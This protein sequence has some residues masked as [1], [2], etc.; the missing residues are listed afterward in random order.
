MKTDRIHGR[1]ALVTGAGRGL[2]EAIARALAARGAR[3]ILCDIDPALLDPLAD[4][5]G[6]VDR[7]VVDVADPDA[8][9][10]LADRIHA[11]HGP[12]GVL[13]NNAGVVAA[14]PALEMPLADWRWMLGVN[15]MGVL[16]GCHVFGPA[17]VAAPGR[18]H[19]VNIASAA[20]FNGLPRMS[21]YAVSK[22]AV[23]S[24]S[25]SL[26]MEIPHGALGISV[27]CPGFI[28]TRLA[29]TGRYPAGAAGEAIKASAARVMDRRGR[30]PADVGRAVISAIDRDRFLVPLYTESW[31]ALAG[32]SLPS[33]VRR[34]LT[35]LATRWMGD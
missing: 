13:V 31:L 32:R 28:P 29:E 26:R 21:G 1:L 11:E 35:R 15:L 3:L 6:A 18:G 8:M 23:L 10:A 14:G 25:E 20:G 27:I 24:W 34:G 7:A 22:A 12:L 5:L 33:T 19:I 30:S 17:M 9:Q 4:E 2:G 16:H